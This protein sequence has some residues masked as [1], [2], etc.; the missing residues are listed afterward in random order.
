MASSLTYNSTTTVNGS[1][2]KIVRSPS[3]YTITADPGVDFVSVPKLTCQATTAVVSG[4]GQTY[5]RSFGYLRIYGGWWQV[6]NGSVYGALGIED[7]IPGTM[8]IAT[9]H[10]ILADVN[11]TDG[12]AYYNSGTLNL[13]TYPGVTVSVLG[14]NANTGYGGDEADYDYFKAKMNTFSKTAWSG[15]SQPDYNGGSGNYEIYTYTGD[16]TLNWSPAAGQRVIYLIDG[17]VTVSGNITVPTTGSTFLAVFASRGITINT[18]V[19]RVDGWWVARTLTLPC[20]DTSPADGTCDE[21][22]V[23]FTGQGSFV[24][25]DSL[26]LARDQNLTNN[27]QPSETFVY[28]PDLLINA[29]DP[30]LVSKY[31]WRYL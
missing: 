25:Y 26:T 10:M 24:G 28:R 1:Y 2:S 16:A 9:R 21:T 20:V 3:T 17:N 11:G 19:T 18:D 13:G 6:T 30:I 23:Q 14:T 12:L 29:P 5:T 8:P 22:D 27:S 7:T 31:I 4:Q 15:V